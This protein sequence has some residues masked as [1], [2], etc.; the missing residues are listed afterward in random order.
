M[1]G[2]ISQKVP[3]GICCF[4]AGL[5]FS[6]YHNNSMKF[7]R[8]ELSSL[9]L[10][11]VGHFGCHF[12][13]LVYP[14]AAIALAQQ[15]GLPF[16]M[17]IG[18]SFLGYFIFGLGGLPVGF[19]ADRLKARWV[20]V[21]CVLGLGPALMLVALAQPGRQL[22]LALAVVG[23][24]ASLY[25]PAALGL[26][27]RTHV[28][29]G[30]ALGINGIFGN[31]GIALAPILTEFTARAWGWRGA[32]LAA[33]ALLILPGLAVAF[34]RVDEPASGQVLPEENS[35]D[36]S[37][38]MKLFIL[39]LVAMTF[40]GLGYRAATVAQPAY[41]AE[42]VHFMGYG[43]ATT[44]VYIVGA[45]G[46]YIGGRL[47]DRH[48]L[49]VLYLVFHAISLPFVFCMAVLSGAP[50]L[51]VAGMFLFFNLS[52]QPI[53]NSLVARFTPDRWRSTAYGFKFTLTFSIGALS[54]WG[55][56]SIIERYTLA[57]VFP[58]IGGVMFL[59]VLTAGLIVW[60][61]RGQKLLNH[62]SGQ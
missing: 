53:E 33:G 62:G 21:T 47:A 55:V 9:Q 35:R 60:R 12:A 16:D 6:Q 34:L 42:K 40:G 5:I 44:L 31:F 59:V 39:L 45:A 32:Y 2:I 27:S 1:Q 38:H 49:S 10:A 56:Q 57:H 48:D 18:W 61:T 46:Q 14:T 37:E 28:R 36:S 22:I 3:T 8:N 30:T 7:S 20:V 13:M 43:V 25:H 52:M 24:F 4:T 50:L 23:V 19:L 58:A 15:E 29:R 17:V 26:L 54:V 51:G 11:S 41:F